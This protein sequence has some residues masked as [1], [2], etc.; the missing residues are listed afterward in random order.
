MSFLAS[1]S[2]FVTFQLDQVL[3]RPP[4]SLALHGEV[5]V[6]AAGIAGD[7]LEFGAGELVEEAREA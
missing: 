5:D 4:T 6:V 3:L 1:Q 2:R 7:D